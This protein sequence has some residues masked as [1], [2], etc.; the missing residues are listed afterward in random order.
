MKYTLDN[1]NDKILLKKTKTALTF[2]EYEEEVILYGAYSIGSLELLYTISL[3]QAVYEEKAEKYF[4]DLIYISVNYPNIKRIC[5]SFPNMDKTIYNINGDKC[6]CFKLVQYD[7]L[8]AYKAISIC[9][10]VA[11]EMIH[12]SLPCYKRLFSAPIVD[13]CDKL[14]VYEALENYGMY[15][16]AS[17]GNRFNNESNYHNNSL[18]EDAVEHFNL[19][20]STSGINYMLKDIAD[21]YITEDSKETR[22]E[23]TYNTDSYIRCCLLIPDD[24]SISTAKEVAK[25]TLRTYEGKI[26]TTAFMMY[27]LMYTLYDNPETLINI[28]MENTSEITQSKVGEQI[29]SYICNILLEDKT[30]R[31]ADISK[32]ID[33][34][35]GINPAKRITIKRAS[36]G[37]TVTM[38]V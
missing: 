21:G 26:K 16:K 34:I 38:Q 9:K 36:T 17:I 30:Y 3:A 22:E 5:S 2:K 20:F 25:S 24:K 18:L 35:Y 33:S 8:R 14:Y 27:T 28:L 4:D 7:E 15:I 13:D 37:R 23:M 31:K 10:N 11:P 32:M 19:D 12:H 6:Y 29:L 1:G